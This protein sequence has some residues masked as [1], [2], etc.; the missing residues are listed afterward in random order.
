M[1]TREGRSVKITCDKCGAEQLVASGMRG[2]EINDEDISRIAAMGEWIV[3][4]DGETECEKCIT[5]RGGYED[6]SNPG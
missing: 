2:E 5:K 4:F 1:V 6:I 3:E